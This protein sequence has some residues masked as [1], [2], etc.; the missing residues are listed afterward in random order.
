MPNI[1]VFFYLPIEFCDT[2]VT[3]NPTDAK[4]IGNKVV[5]SS[6]CKS[7]KCVAD[8]KLTSRLVDLHR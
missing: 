8:L 1:L 6:G 7:S 4:V 3:V 5:F 2:C